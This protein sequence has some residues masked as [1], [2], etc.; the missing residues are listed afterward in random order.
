MLARISRRKRVPLIRKRLPPATVSALALL[1]LAKIALCAQECLREWMRRS[2]ECPCCRQGF[3][4]ARAPVATAVPVARGISR[5]STSSEDAHLVVRVHEA[6]AEAQQLDLIF[7]DNHLRWA[8]AVEDYWR[9]VASSHPPGSR[10]RQINAQQI[11]RAHFQEPA[12]PVFEGDVAGD[13]LGARAMNQVNTGQMYSQ[14]PAGSE[15][16]A[17]TST[18][19]G[20]SSDSEGSSNAGSDSGSDDS[21]HGPDISI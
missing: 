5:R 4:H 10:L 20:S 2:S 17:D 7:D 19:G 6:V 3:T 13:V 15:L 1:P 14:D 9:R 16:E 12:E 18:A 21:E 11:S 8:R